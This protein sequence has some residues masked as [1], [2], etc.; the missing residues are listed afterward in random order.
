MKKQLLLWIVVVVAGVLA[1]TVAMKAYFDWQAKKRTVIPSGGGHQMYSSDGLFDHVQC[2]FWNTRSGDYFYGMAIAHV[3]YEPIM[4]TISGVISTTSK[5][6]G[7]II[8]GKQID[9]SPAKRLL[10]LNPFGQM[11]E[12]ILYTAIEMQIIESRD[13]EKIWRDI[14][15]K[16]LYVFDGLE[17]NGKRVGHWV[18][19]DTSGRK[20]YEGDYIDGKREGKWTYYYQSGAVKAEVNYSDG[21]RHGKW[22]YFDEGGKQTKS[23]DWDKGHVAKGTVRQEGFGWSAE[24]TRG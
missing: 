17:K 15:V 10:A 18:C 20:A 2:I 23:V 13:R 24:Q 1:A 3:D 9:Y 7:L 22:T 8:N 5:G 16:R 12:I 19:S 6:D 4:P 21:Q 11:E 14:A